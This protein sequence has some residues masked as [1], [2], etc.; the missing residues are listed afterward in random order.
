MGATN[1]ADLERQLRLA[2]AVGQFEEH[3]GVPALVGPVHRH[4]KSLRSSS[5]N[6]AMR[7]G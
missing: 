2:S 6:A 3:F 7:S 1:G 4:P 5:G